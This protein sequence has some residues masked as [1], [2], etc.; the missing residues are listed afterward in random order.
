MAPVAIVPE[1]FMRIAALLCSCLLLAAPASAEVLRVVVDSRADVLA[2]KA[3][4]KTGPYEKLW[5]TISFGVDPK[6]PANQAITDL[7]YAP[8]N[9]QGKVEFSANFLL[10]RPKDM[11]RGNGTVL[12]DLA[13]RGT[14]RSLT[15]FNHATADSGGFDAPD[16]TTPANFG[17]GFLMEEGFTLLWLGWQFDIPASRRGAMRADVPNV[18]ASAGIEGMVR[19]DFVV[20]ADEKVEGPIHSWLLAD[21][22][23]TPYAVS[24]PEAAGTQL[25][26][27]DSAEGPRQVIPRSEW[28]FA[29]VE[30]GQP[31]RDMT[32]VYLKSGFQKNRIYEAIYKAANP[33]VAGLMMAVIRDGVSM[34]K[35]A[36][37][38]ELGVPPG[39]IAHVI[40]FG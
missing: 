19:I 7:K 18:L 25:T 36:P 26:V 20:N 24:D 32:R 14:K 10:I 11:Q 30:N 8:V 15:H 39:S 35:Y 40:G 31:V 27:R 29:R 28:Q 6:N 1:T 33:A 37:A 9:A 13:N 38:A 23:H 12:L 3:F 16:P 2:G 22:N 5:G 34:V 21:R 4:G 17:D